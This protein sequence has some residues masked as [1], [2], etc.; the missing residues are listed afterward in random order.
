MHRRLFLLS[1]LAAPMAQAEA[2]EFTLTEAEWRA[3]LSDLAYRVLREE[4]TERPNTSRLN[5]EKRPGTY[6]C[7]GCDLPVF[8]SAAK[9]DSGTGWPSFWEP[10]PDA[11]RTRED[12][13]LIGSRTEVHCR[14][15]GGHFGHVFKDGPPPTG[16]RYCIN[17][18]A[19][20][21][22]AV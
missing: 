6:H 22:V 13:G 10:L 11:V 1:V 18:I 15:C 2:F 5:N 7:K 19:L 9:Y 16:L 17:G 20:Q 4:A 8:S 14:R 3:R 21:F 12:G